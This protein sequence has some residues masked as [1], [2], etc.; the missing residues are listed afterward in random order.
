MI[1]VFFATYTPRTF[2]MQNMRTP[3]ST[4]PRTTSYQ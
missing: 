2:R 4:D 1:Y 3:T